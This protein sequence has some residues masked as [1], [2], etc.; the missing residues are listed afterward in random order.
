MS[1][2]VVS[3][4]GPRP[5]RIPGREATCGRGRKKGKGREGKGCA[6]GAQAAVE[7]TREW[8]RYGTNTIRLAGGETD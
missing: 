1:K 2:G 8:G 7:T 3:R 5:R 4:P 6:R